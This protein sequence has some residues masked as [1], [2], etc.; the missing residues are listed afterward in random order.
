MTATEA[1]N[2][3]NFWVNLPSEVAM[4]LFSEVGKSSDAN[5]M[6]LHGAVAENGVSVI[7][8]LVQIS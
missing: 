6:A 8:R 5:I 4:V 7:D 2:L 1:Q 3:A